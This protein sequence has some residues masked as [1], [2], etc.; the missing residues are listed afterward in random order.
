MQFVAGRRPVGA[1]RWDLATD[2]WTWDESITRLHGYGPSEAPAP[3]TELIIVHTMRSDR[4]AVQEL[5]EQLRRDPAPFAA[6]VR[7]RS[8]AGHAIPVTITGQPEPQRPRV[9][10]GWLVPL[11][12]DAGTDGEPAAADPRDTVAELEEQVKHLHRALDTRDVIGRAKGILQVRLGLDDQAAFELL[13]RTSQNAN[14]RLVTVA[15]RLVAHAGT[16]Q[17]PE[18]ARRAFGESLVRLVLDPG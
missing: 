7:V 6:V 3:T 4:D 16:T 2:G 14:V 8:T 5:L 17:V 10:S 12:T 9:L 13:S 11:A 18:Q 15:E 1:W